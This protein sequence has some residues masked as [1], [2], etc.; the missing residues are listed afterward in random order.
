M[1]VFEEKDWIKFFWKEVGDE[2]ENVK[3]WEKVGII[4][5][6]RVRLFVLDFRIVEWMRRFELL[7]E[8]VERVVKIVVFEEEI[9]GWI[10]GKFR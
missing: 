6:V 4:E 1:L 9:E 2:F 10:K 3:E 7:K 8:D 5:V